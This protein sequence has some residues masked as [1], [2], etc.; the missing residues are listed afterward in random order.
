MVPTNNT[1]FR[2]EV[3]NRNVSLSSIDEAQRLV[4]YWSWLH[5]IRSFFPLAGAALGLTAT[6]T[7]DMS[8]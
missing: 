4:K 1:L 2:L 8:I 3:E 7:N 6:L 5:L